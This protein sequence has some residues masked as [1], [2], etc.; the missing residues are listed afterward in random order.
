M[1]DFSRH[2]PE[3]R[4]VGWKK[5]LGFRDADMNLSTLVGSP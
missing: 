5:L 3:A 1:P 2:E 4:G